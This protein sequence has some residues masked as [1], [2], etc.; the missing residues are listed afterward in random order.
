M[1]QTFTKDPDATLDYKIPWD[2]WLGSDTIATSTWLISGPDSALVVDSDTNTTTAATI[3][4][5]GG[6]L[7]RQYTATNRITTAGGRGD[8][9]TITINIENK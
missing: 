3:W 5:S 6:T 4:L 7:Y 9:R 1:P 2:D 8:D